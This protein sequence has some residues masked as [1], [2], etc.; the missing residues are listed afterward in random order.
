MNAEERAARTSSLNDLGKIYELVLVGMERGGNDPSFDQLMR[1]DVFARREVPTLVQ[2]S[3]F[4]LQLLCND[5][6]ALEKKLED[7]EKN[8]LDQELSDRNK[9]MQQ[10][11]RRT[12]RKKP[13]IA[14]LTKSSGATL[15]NKKKKA[16]TKRTKKKPNKKQ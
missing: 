10:L 14:S 13:Q 7:H 9:A 3:M 15:K 8:A 2:M 6:N 16:T 1:R 12:R 11:Q 4:A 5:I